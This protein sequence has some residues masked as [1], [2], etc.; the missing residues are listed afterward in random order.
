MKYSFTLTIILLIFTT[1]MFSQERMVMMSQYVHNQ[2]MLNSA[3]GGSRE[4]LSLFGSYRQQ[5]VGLSLDSTISINPPKSQSITVHAPL[6]N[7]HIALG[8]MIYHESYGM[9]DGIKATLSYTYRVFTDNGNKIALSLNGGLKSNSWGKGMVEIEYID[10]NDPVLDEV[11]SDF[12]NE[13]RFAMGFGTAWYGKNFFL[14]FSIY[15]FFYHKPFDP[16]N[17]DDSFFA[18]GKS[19][20]LLTGGYLYDVSEIF[21]IQPSALVNFEPTLTKQITADISVSAI[22]MNTFWFGGTYRT[23][24]E[25]VG[26]FGWQINPQFRATYSYDF[27]T[28]ELKKFSAGSH[29]ISLQYDFGYKINTS[30][31]KFF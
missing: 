18:L 1:S 16:N 4:A 14:G 20:Y 8:G 3:F 12:Q 24:K 19:S 6:K 25:L 23:N 22:I 11:P 21:A 2:Y 30:S 17:S 10:P 7:E 9:Y 26:M 31:P 13:N 15:D 29:E 27:P 5:W 28:G